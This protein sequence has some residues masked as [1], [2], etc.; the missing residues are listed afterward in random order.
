MTMS[1]LPGDVGKTTLQKGW[2]MRCDV[3]EATEGAL[4]ILQPLRRLTYI[5]STSP[6][7]P[8]EQP[9]VV[10]EFKLS[11]NYNYSTYSAHIHQNM[12]IKSLTKTYGKPF[13]IAEKKM[14][15]RKF[16]R[17]PILARM[18]GELTDLSK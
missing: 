18:C 15:I 13:C 5:T 1:G 14:Y 9:M 2:R 16:A 6:M 12:L 3:A 17:Q 11:L 8:G 10:I 4:V 7:S